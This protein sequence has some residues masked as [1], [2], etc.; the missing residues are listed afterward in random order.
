M[1]TAFIILYAIVL[2]IS[3]ILYNRMVDKLRFKH[4]GVTAVNM[5][6]RRPLPGNF[7]LYRKEFGD[8]KDMMRLWWAA[9][10]LR[11][12]AILLTPFLIAA[13]NILVNP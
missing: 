3:Y 8:Q 4:P 10:V 11:W 5:S 7:A 12:V 1:I 9:R 13:V 6:F 2:A